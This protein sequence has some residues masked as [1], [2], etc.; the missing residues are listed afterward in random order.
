MSFR[1]R[2]IFE[3]GVPLSGLTFDDSYA[4]REAAHWAGGGSIHYW[5]DFCALSGDEQS[6][7][8]AHWMAK[9]RSDAVIAQ[10]MERKRRAAERRARGRG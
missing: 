2:P 7:I 9:M 10:D 5:N 3:I 1:G 4:W 8:V 6:A